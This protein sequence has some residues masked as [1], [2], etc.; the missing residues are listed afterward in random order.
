MFYFEEDIVTID[1]PNDPGN[2]DTPPTPPATETAE[3]KAERLEEQNRKLFERAKR[4]E[5]FVK[6]P[7]GTW[8]KAQPKPSTLQT[9][10]PK[11]DDEIIQK[12]NKLELSEKK[13]EIGYELGLSPQETDKLFKFAGSS[14]PKE[15]FKDP[16]FQAGLTEVRRAESV[17]KAIPSSTN[18]STVIEGK[19]FADMTSEERAKNWD[20]IIKK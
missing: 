9:P 13:R 5:G 1:T 18:R 3:E 17:A 8:V 14:D 19:T 12:V 15:A 7:D 6:Q 16:F 4:A 20:K 10:T 11:V 2:T